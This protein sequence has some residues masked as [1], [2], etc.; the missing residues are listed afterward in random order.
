MPCALNTTRL[1]VSN[2]ARGWAEPWPT[3]SRGQDDSSVD[4]ASMITLSAQRPNT[5]T[6]GQPAANRW[7]SIVLVW[8]GA[9]EADTNVW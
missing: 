3:T 9:P 5:K 8:R 4:V 7:P 1:E 2:V 6:V